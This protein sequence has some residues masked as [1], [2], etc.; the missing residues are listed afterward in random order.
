M[1]KPILL[2]AS[3]QF[4]ARLSCLLFILIISSCK[5][6][7][8]ILEEHID[9]LVPEIVGTLSEQNY[10]I[11]SLNS[12]ILY[13]GD[14]VDFTSRIVINNDTLVI[15]P[16]DT[17]L[18]LGK[19]YTATSSNST[20]KLY[21]TEIPI[22]ALTTVSPDIPDDPKEPGTITIFENNVEPY[23]SNIGIEVRGGF[24]QSFPKQSYSVELWEELDGEDTKSESLLGLRDDDDWILD[25][26]WNEPLRVRDFSSHALWLQMARFNYSEDEPEAVLGIQRKYCELFLN[27]AYRGVYYLGEKVDRKQLK[28]KKFDEVIRGE[29]YKGD[30]HGDG[31]NF[32]GVEPISNSEFYWSGYE[33]KYPDEIG[34]FDWSN[35]QSFVD[36]VVNS[37][38]ADFDSE[39]ENWLDIQNA[40]DYYLFMNITYAQDNNGKNLYT[41]RYDTDMPY[42]F[43]AWDMDGTFGNEWSGERYDNTDFILSNGLFDRLITSP[44]F[45][46]ELKSRWATLQTSNLSAASLKKLLGD[47][48][49]YLK[50]NGVYQR[51]ALYEDL[52]YRYSEEEINFI[53][54]W[55]DSRIT[56]LDNHISNL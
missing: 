41:A 34:E 47:N 30:S 31:V 18:D 14:A 10:V 20:F 28:L 15:S 56:F 23:Q 54:S 19:E 53:N 51:E 4:C 25:G 48:Y 5:K 32:Y 29:L 9:P 38:T 17:K 55:I 3:L 21:R 26:L 49:E 43:V 1:K 12:L 36:F 24:S 44:I 45:V 16:A 6:E 50:S 11:D 40:V 46:T 22:I 42:L 39:I 37:E 33:M 7:N 13:N 35:I 52:P 27:G 8:T 2:S